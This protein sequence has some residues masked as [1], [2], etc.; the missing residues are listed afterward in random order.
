MSTYNVWIHHVGTT[1]GSELRST[2]LGW[3]PITCN[4][5]EVTYN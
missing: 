3:I 2:K 4:S 1:D 5:Y